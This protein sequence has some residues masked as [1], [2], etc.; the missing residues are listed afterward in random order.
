MI[1]CK[2]GG[3]WLLAAMETREPKRML[4]LKRTA[5]NSAY[6]PA[7][8]SEPGNERCHWPA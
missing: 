8:I 1:L 2:E 5:I 4:E 6:R 3:F 7:P